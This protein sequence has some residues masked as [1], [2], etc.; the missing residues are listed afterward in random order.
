MDP[1]GAIA[2]PLKPTK[3]TLFN[4]IFYNSENSIRNIRPFGRALFCHNSA[5]KYTSTLLQ[6]RSRYATWLSNI[7]EIAPPLTLLV[8]SAPGLG[9]IK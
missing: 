4:M 2:L 7:T 5:V 1:D 6:Q 8:G 9:V 3:V